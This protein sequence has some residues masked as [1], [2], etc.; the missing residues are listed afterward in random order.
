MERIGIRGPY[1]RGF[2]VAD[3]EGRDLVIVAGGLGM[4]PLRSLVRWVLA[5][6]AQVGETTLIYG[7]RSPA[8]LLFREEVYGWLQ[9]GA[10]RVLLSVDVAPA[11]DWNGIVGPVTLPLRKVAVNPARTSAFVVGPPVMVQ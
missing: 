2:P 11:G 8:D 10:I 6:R 4:A 5:H 9:G 1:G 7:T 3:L